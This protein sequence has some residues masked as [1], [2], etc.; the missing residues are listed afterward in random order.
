[1]AIIPSARHSHTT[2]ECFDIVA[3]LRFYHDL[4]GLRTVRHEIKA[5][6][7]IASN[8]HLTVAVQMAT[9]TPQPRGNLYAR[10]V[11]DGKEVDRVHRALDA[12][13]RSAYGLRFVGEPCVAS[14]PEFGVSTYGFE[15]QD[16]DGNWWRIEENAGPF[17][18][19][20][21]PKTPSFNSIVPEGPIGYVMLES[22]RLLSTL[23]FYR[24]VLGFPVEPIDDRHF[25]TG[26]GA[27]VNAIVVEAG[28]MLVPQTV[29]NHHGVTLP[30]S[31]GRET[32]DAVRTRLE[33]VATDYG[34]AK[35][36]KP[37]AQHGSYS[38]YWQDGD[39]NWWEL[40]ILEEGLNPWQRAN[41]RLARG[42]L[43]HAQPHYAVPQGDDD[44]TRLGALL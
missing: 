40:E 15:L 37:S 20:M 34:I 14:A 17:G 9:V 32:V 42:E 26:D 16:L 35:I 18:P 39:T 10:V 43:Q 8:E 28:T 30:T 38:F 6:V 31:A 11:R 12:R 33:S 2:L 7:F 21:I 3:S 4:L 41:A 13:V 22:R 24:D 1:V 27:A 19:I 25:R 36:M 23:R 29:M 44:I 5:G